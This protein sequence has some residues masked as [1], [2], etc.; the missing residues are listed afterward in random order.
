M[1]TSKKLLLFIF[2]SCL[3]L[4][5]GIVT[6]T[7]MENSKQKAELR[8]KQLSKTENITANPLT[9]STAINDW[10][11]YKSRFG[12]SFSFPK[13]WVIKECQTKEDCEYYP[14]TS[15]HFY[16]ND[17]D[18]QGSY[19]QISFSSPGTSQCIF[20]LVAN[21]NQIE[22]QYIDILKYGSS[23]NP[24]ITMPIKHKETCFEF[25]GNFYSTEEKATLE[26]VLAS[27]K[28]ED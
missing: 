4:V 23:S 18:I 10:Y 20:D 22:K 2:F 1:N 25:L 21:N 9:E 6:Y 12:Y 7:K 11:F 14:A 19:L 8:N 13:S 28:F 15:L 24:Q 3:I 16:K 26:K 27:F 17:S 5:I